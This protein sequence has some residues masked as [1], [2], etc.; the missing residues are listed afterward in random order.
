MISKVSN[1][2]KSVSDN[3][4]IY[5][6]Y[7]L[8]TYFSTYLT[9]TAKH[10]FNYS[11]HLFIPSMKKVFGL[12]LIHLRTAASTSASDEV[13]LLKSPSILETTRSLMVP[14]LGCKEGV[15]PL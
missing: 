11:I 3:I 10:L 14:N 9:F 15:E 4:K 13:D 8:Y 2:R 5:S 1:C 7:T 6:S 12:V